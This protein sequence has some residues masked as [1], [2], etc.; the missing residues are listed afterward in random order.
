MP[1]VSIPFVL[2]S[3]NLFYFSLPCRSRPNREAEGSQG[4][5]TGSKKE[6]NRLILPLATTSFSATGL[7]GALHPDD[8]VYQY[9]N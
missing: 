1:W 4:G 6:V 2:F 3:I 7:L 8:F 9:L 5:Y